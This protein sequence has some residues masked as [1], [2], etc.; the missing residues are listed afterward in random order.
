[1]KH[2]T[3]HLTVHPIESE[4]PT[5]QSRQSFEVTPKGRAVW[6]A[7]SEAYGDGWIRKHGEKANFSWCRNLEKF[8]KEEIAEAVDYFQNHGGQFPPSLPDFISAC[9]IPRDRAKGMQK[10][11]ATPEP[12][13]E[14]VEANLKKLKEI[15]AG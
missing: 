2:V 14:L 11:L 6:V 15:M 10:R 1:M 7:M 12:D 3:E 13:P 4:K 9:R 8:S 5:A